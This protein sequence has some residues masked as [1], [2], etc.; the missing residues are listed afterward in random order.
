MHFKQTILLTALS[1]AAVASPMTS[2]GQAPS[3]PQSAHVYNVIDLD[4]IEQASGNSTLQRRVPWNWCVQ[5]GNNLGK[6]DSSSA[7]KQY[8]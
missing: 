8:Y 4:Q 3:A 5:D 6:T 1:T 7:H 2:E